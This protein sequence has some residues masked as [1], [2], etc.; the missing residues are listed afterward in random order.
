MHRALRAF[1]PAL[2][3]L[4][5]TASVAD[6][7]KIGGTGVA[8]GGMARLG[9]AF[10]KLHP[11]T[12]VEVLPSL[13]SSGGVKAVLAGAI[14]VGVSSR[15]LKDAERNAM[16]TA[17]LYAYTPL[18]VVTS[19]GTEANEITTKELEAI[20]A[21]EMTHWPDGETIRV[22]MRPA[23]ETDTQ[24]LRNLSDGMAMAVDKAFTRP[25]LITATTDQEN[26]ET[27]EH[28][29]GTI[30][31]VALGQIATEERQLKILSLNGEVPEVGWSSD[32]N[33]AFGKSLYLVSGP[34]P[35]SLAREFVDFVYSEEGRDI[36]LAFDHLPMN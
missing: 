4:A 34:E 9:E 24:L 17:R 13:G 31:V 2:A 5:S 8:L 20:Y 22:I 28:L 25:G 36:L 11:G 12:T 7:L 3:I 6:T 15:A 14:D 27:L 26:A 16:A 19:L 23:T 29:P 33:T 10:E 35:S 1:L 32:P 21:G 18:A 30:G